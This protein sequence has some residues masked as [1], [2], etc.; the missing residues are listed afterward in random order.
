MLKLKRRQ[1]RSAIRA[2]LDPPFS[3]H[4][5]E[6]LKKYEEPRLVDPEDREILERYTLIGWVHWGYSVTHNCETA[7]LTRKAYPI[8]D[9]WEWRFK[10]AGLL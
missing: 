4:E 2:P 9:Y 10:E 5:L 3:L 1:S 7:R 8:L 6:V